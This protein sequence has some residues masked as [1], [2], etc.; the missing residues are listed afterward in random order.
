MNKIPSVTLGI[1]GEYR[2]RLYGEDGVIKHDSGWH[3]NMILDAGPWMFVQGTNY[4]NH[5]TLG[6]SNTP[7]VSTQLGIQGS[8][9]GRVAQPGYTGTYGTNW[10]TPPYYI[11]ILAPYQ[12]NTGV[13]TGTINEFVM[14]AD[15]DNAALNEAAVRVVLATPIVKGAQ[16]QLIIEYRLYTYPDVTNNSGTFDV[17]GVDYDIEMGWGEIDLITGG[18]SA[19]TNDLLR[20]VGAFL[21]NPRTINDFITQRFMINGVMPVDIFTRPTGDTVDPVIGWPDFTS[22]ISNGS[23]PYKNITLTADL[24]SMNGT[25]DMF[26]ICG[27]TNPYGV[28]WVSRTFKVTRTSDSAPFTKEDTHVVTFQYRLYVDKYVP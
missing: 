9:L 24:D 12:F 19:T 21:S 3:D 1:R 17:S 2:A 22:Y 16:D 20:A 10:G 15:N 18:W 26:E 5:M 14:S 13:A 27:N 11:W 23:P 7:A 4:V 25:F 6:T 8:I 28:Y